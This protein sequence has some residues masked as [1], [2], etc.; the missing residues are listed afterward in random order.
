[1][2]DPFGRNR[3]EGKPT[4]TDV[5]GV[6]SPLSFAGQPA[7]PSGGAPAAAGGSASAPPTV[8]GGGTAPQAPGSGGF[9]DLAGS[10]FPD[11][12]SGGPGAGDGGVGAPGVGQATDAA[13]GPANIGLGFGIGPVGLNI[14]PT[15]TIGVGARGQSP[16]S[17]LFSTALNTALTAAGVPTSVNIPSLVATLTQSGVLGTAAQLAGAF[18]VPF[19]I[20]S[21]AHAIA[22]MSPT[23]VT[24]LQAML[25]TPE[26]KITAAQAL[27]L[28]QGGARG[29]SV[30]GP[31]PIGLLSID[32]PVNNPAG[33]TQ[34]APTTPA[35]NLAEAATPT[36]TFAAL[37][38]SLGLGSGREDSSTG[39][40]SGPGASG[41]GP[42][43]GTASGDSST[44][45][46]PGG[47]T[48]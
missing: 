26:G 29:P 4:T 20:A 14:G 32:N 1:M 6:V 30:G 12:G 19:T 31:Q 25:A 37:A 38:A 15:G 33:T 39:G 47:S 34:A 48:Y 8:A 18:G 23:S 21:L 44:G 42:G 24:N 27:A 28:A 7:L 16:E 17:G 45:G 22:S 9:G 10:A 11:A 41:A 2:G 35:L 13:G 36:P 3:E 5:F 46:D 43:A 40:P